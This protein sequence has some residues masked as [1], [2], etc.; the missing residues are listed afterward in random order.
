MDFSAVQ[1][2]FLSN[3]AGE[4]SL[5]VARLVKL[6]LVWLGLKRAEFSEFEPILLQ[7][8]VFRPRHC[9]KDWSALRGSEHHSLELTFLLFFFHFSE[10]YVWERY[11]LRLSYWSG[12]C[13]ASRR[14]PLNWGA[15]HKSR[16]FWYCSVPCFPSFILSLSICLSRNFELS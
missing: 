3:E 6:G 14:G 5:S 15:Y 8:E 9:V 1:V 13:L 7:K 10:S 12:I 2:N 4:R 11:M 16:T